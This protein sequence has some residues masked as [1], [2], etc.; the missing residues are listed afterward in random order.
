MSTV[1]IIR[2]AFAAIVLIE[3]TLKA[4]AGTP[5]GRGSRVLTINFDSK[6][7]CAATTHIPT[8]FERGASIASDPF[9]MA[10]NFA[11]AAVT[12]FLEV[13]LAACKSCNAPL[14]SITICTTEDRIHETTGVWLALV[15][16][17]KQRLSC[18]GQP[19]IRDDSV[20]IFDCIEHLFFLAVDVTIFAAS[21]RCHASVVIVRA[22]LVRV[23]LEPA[24]ATQHQ[25]KQK[26]GPKHTNSPRRP[27]VFE[28]AHGSAK[29]FKEVKGRIYGTN[30]EFRNS[31][32]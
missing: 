7:V 30:R 14:N 3:P 15:G 25:Y 13:A 17:A 4:F 26:Q 28:A 2:S 16:A 10:W 21:S 6:A 32:M 19:F 11:G 22:R 18:V 24:D 1:A 27:V 29:P 8:V 20:A 9:G 12:T 5:E 31:S 23:A